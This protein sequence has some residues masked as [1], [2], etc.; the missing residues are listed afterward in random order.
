[1]SRGR[2]R[3]HTEGGSRD[4]SIQNQLGCSIV[5][6]SKWNW[7]DLYSV[8]L[9]PHSHQ[10]NCLCLVFRLPVSCCG[11]RVILRRFRAVDTNVLDSERAFQI[12][13]RR[14]HVSDMNGLVRLTLGPA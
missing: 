13:G 3:R 11:N 12:V 4:L 8:L 9:Q 6:T 7:K 1:M 10:P 2:R 5:P 14:A